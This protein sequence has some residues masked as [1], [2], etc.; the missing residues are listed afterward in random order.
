MTILDKLV[1]HLEN[2]PGIGLRQARR[3]AYYLSARP[4][5]ELSELS[6]LINR[7]KS[8]VIKCSDCCRLFTV[9]N[10]GQG[11]RCGICAD[12]NRDLSRLMVVENDA[13]AS[14]VEKTGQYNGLY[15]VL[16]G[17]IPILGYEDKKTG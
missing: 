10:N 16:G 17:T 7:L 12:T 1:K 8:E 3:L 13:D 5:S 9:T 2:F 6:V 11:Q 4:D 14:A 15:F